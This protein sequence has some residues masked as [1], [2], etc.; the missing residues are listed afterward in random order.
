M[1][2]IIITNVDTD[3]DDFTSSS[4]HLFIDGDAVKL[5]A[6]TAPGGTVNE[7]IYYAR[8]IDSTKFAIHAIRSDARDNINQ[9]ALSSQGVDVTFLTGTPQIKTIDESRIVNHPGA[10]PIPVT[11]SDYARELVFVEGV[12]T[13]YTRID[14][15][16]S[17]AMK[18]VFGKGITSS[19]TYIFTDGSPKAAPGAPE[20][21]EVWIVS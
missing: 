14:V 15:L 1:P 10:E 7:T 9:I 18:S 19:P 20:I 6:T 3:N 11:F 2:T 13:D 17:T 4:P 16:H 21:S 12:N 8:V 5:S